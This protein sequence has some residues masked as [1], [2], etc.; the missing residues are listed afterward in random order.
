MPDAIRFTKKALINKPAPH[1]ETLWIAVHLPALQ[2]EVFVPLWQQMKCESA[3]VVLKQN[4]VIAMSDDAHK[5]GVR[6]DMRRGGVQMLLPEAQ[7]F[8]QDNER[9]AAAISAIALAL[10][11]YTPQVSIADNASILLDIGASLRLFGGLRSLR[12]QIRCTVNTLGYSLTTGCAPTAKSA[13]LFAIHAARYQ[14][15][16]R[17]GHVCLQISRLHKALDQLPIHLLMNALAWQDFLHGLA[18]YRLADLRALPRPGL[19]RRCGTALLEELDQAYSLYSAPQIWVVADPEFHARLELPDR[20]DSTDALFSY[21]RNL[22][23]QLSGWLNAHHLAVKQI[24]LELQHERGRQAV[25]P[26]MLDIQLAEA[27]WQ[28]AHLLPLF[29]EKL[30]QI[31]LPTAVIA[32]SMHA[33]H[34]LALEAPSNSLFPDSLSRPEEHQHLLALLV[35]RLGAN[36]V[37]RP[38][39]K[40]DHRPEVANQWG[41]VMH[42]DKLSEKNV[43]S[44]SLL[45]PSWLLN[46]A[47]PLEVRRHKPCF[48]SELSLISPAERIEAGWWSDQTQVRDYFVAVGADH[49]RYWIYRERP[50]H[51]ENAEPSWFLHGIF[52]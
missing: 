36:H 43:A 3:N 40:A 24:R 6:A 20:L 7:F 5:A 29:K 15:R 4:R 1:S 11:R 45:R 18:C 21:S 42:N 12:Q 41:S 19:Q 33:P 44:T 52:G 9:E 26:S 17:Q 13:W 51:T 27:S 30:A 37:L 34:T 10:L 16:Q 35:A 14:H 38:L 22:L 49:V 39:P 28:E 50:S 32:L 8:V 48:G 46:Q 31:S 23:C 47:I 25:T 2:L